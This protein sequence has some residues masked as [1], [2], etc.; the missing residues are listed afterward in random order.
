MRSSLELASGQ[1]VDAL[2]RANAA[3]GGDD[4]DYYDGGGGGCSDCLGCCGCCDED[5]G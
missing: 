1:R 4:D 5:G 2:H 3:A